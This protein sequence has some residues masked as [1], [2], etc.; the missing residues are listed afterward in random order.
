MKALIIIL[1]LVFPGVAY[2]DSV[3]TIKIE[4]A[5]VDRDF[6]Y[7][8]V[9]YENTTTKTFTRYVT[10]RCEAKNSRG[11]RINSNKRSFFAHE[12]GPIKPGFTGNVKIPIQIYGKEMESVSC[13]CFGK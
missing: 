9:F 1:V 5:W 4:K 3:G 7:V 8:L 6:G 11:K 13:G 10:I 12:V 2:A